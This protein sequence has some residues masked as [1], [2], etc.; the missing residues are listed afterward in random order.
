M[1]WGTC[2]QTLVTRKFT[3]SSKKLALSAAATELYE[4]IREAILANRT[5]SDAQRRVRL[6]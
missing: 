5:L 1:S 4:R 6:P 2:R 3:T